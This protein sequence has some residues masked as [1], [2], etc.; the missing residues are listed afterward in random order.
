MPSSEKGIKKL[1]GVALLK[2]SEASTFTSHITTPPESMRN[3]P[4]KR[5]SASLYKLA[6]LA[7][8]SINAGIRSNKLYSAEA[9]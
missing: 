9:E 4:E 6:P 5:I 7:A 8:I 2:V 1:F 3:K